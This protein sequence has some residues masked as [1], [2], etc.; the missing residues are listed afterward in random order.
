MKKIMVVDDEL[1]ITRLLES[2]LQ[3]SGYSVTA[4]NSG[5]GALEK[6]AQG[7]AFELAIV[8]LRM[9]KVNGHQV[10]SEIKKRDQNTPVLV[11]S[12]SIGLGGDVKEIMKSGIQE[13]DILCKPVD[14]FVL[15]DKIK[16]KLG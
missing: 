4:V 13:S 2:F 5:G 7:E 8:D 14:L 1:E 16:Q 10:I 6:I 11:L 3:K 9:P 12:G 15:L